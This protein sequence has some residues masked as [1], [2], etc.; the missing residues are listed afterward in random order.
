MTLLVIGLFVFLGVHSVRIVAAPWRDAMLTRH[1]AGAWKGLYSLASALGLTLIVYGYGQARLAPVDLWLP[2]LWTR[3][4]AVAL[5][6]PAFVLV[7][8]A[9]VPGNAI[10]ARLGHPMLLG[11][12]VWAAAHL[13]ANGRLADVLLFGGFLVWAAVA[14]GHARRRDRAGTAAPSPARPGAIATVVTVVAGLAGGLLFALRV[15][16]PLIGVAPLG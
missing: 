8:A 16:A 11:T 4:L 3:H 9:Y 2:P 5:T 10:K 14:Y 1:G 6:L 12:K 13:L 15:H 7:T